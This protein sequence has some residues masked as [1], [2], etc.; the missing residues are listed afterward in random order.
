MASAAATITTAIADAIATYAMV[1]T[2]V[3][4]EVK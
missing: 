2:T 3:S 4:S 1:N